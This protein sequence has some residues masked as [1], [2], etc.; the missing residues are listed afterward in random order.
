MVSPN[1][2]L[3]KGLTENYD[4]TLLPGTVYDLL[5]EW[6]VRVPPSP[7]TLS[8]FLYFHS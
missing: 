4:Y 7:F 3:R 6:C 8:T 2:E 5:E 1:G